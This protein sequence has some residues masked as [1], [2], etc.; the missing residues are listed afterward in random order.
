MR[1]FP[2]LFCILLFAYCK[3]DKKE[4][5][6]CNLTTITRGTGVNDSVYFIRYDDA[7]RISNVEDKFHQ[8]TYTISYRGTSND[9]LKVSGSNGFYINYGYNAQDQLISVETS[10]KLRYQ[11]EYSNG[12][13]G[14]CLYSSQSSGTWKDIYWYIPVYDAAGN[15]SEI[16]IKNMSDVLIAVIKMQYSSVP[17]RWHA[18]GFLSLN[19]TAGTGINMN[20]IFYHFE[21]QTNQGKFMLQNYVWISKPGNQ[22]VK[23]DI[24]YEYDADGRIIASKTVGTDITGSVVYGFRKYGY[25]CP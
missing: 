2:V 4:K 16:S 21:A 1:I 3:K 15:M 9:P 13:I 24:D 23:V 17:N 8:T 11:F 5:P 7:I 10:T 6:D 19:A 14:K 25:T 22:E 12:R 18:L 20:D